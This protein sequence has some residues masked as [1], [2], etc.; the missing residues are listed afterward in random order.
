MNAIDRRSF[1]A[2]TGSL[3]VAFALPPAASLAD[4]LAPP[5][6]TVAPDQVDGFIAID[7]KGLVTLYSGK[8]DLGTG[9]RT[10]MTQIV[11]EELD[12]PMDRVTVI[13]GDTALT[14]DQGTSSGS[15]SIQKGGVQIRQAAA[16]ARASLLQMAATT[17]GAAPADLTIA[18]GIITAKTG[19]SVTY[20]ALIGGKT[21]AL[22]LDPKAPLKN[23]DTYTIVGQSKARLDIPPKVFATF[24][25]MHDFKL[26]GMLHGRVVRP[27]GIGAD[28]R[29][30][31][32][33]SV[34]SIPGVVKIVREGNFLGVVA[35]TEW[36][37]IKASRQLKT[38]WSSWDGLPEDGKLWDHVRTTKV[39]K[40]EV[41]SSV[42]DV[43]SALG[44]GAKRIKATYDFA[45]HT[46]GS[47]GPSCAV[48]SFD[49]DGHLTCWS[50][51]QATHNLVKQ[52]SVMLGMPADKIRCIYIDGSGCYGRNGHEDAAADAVLMAKAVGQPV[53][54]QWMREDEHGWD[55]KG[56]PT[57]IDL[58]AALDDKGDI[59]AWSSAFFIPQ[60]AAGTVPLVAAN[61]TDKPHETIL[62]PGG[63]TGNSALPY[64]LP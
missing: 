33:A 55:P 34:G 19:A 40:D 4:P 12:V 1:L 57:L 3:V 62:A 58:E 64:T 32:E 52:L 31:D 22:K 49:A 21:F 51:S 45:I 5:S 35:K 17:L 39:A 26:P 6:K 29:G 23:P 2:S 20:A 38:S 63:I 54:V 18:D 46:H 15:L 50:A 44:K 27:P 43:T 53:R 59:L 48:A 8:V 61:L 11:A 60:G 42:G 28:L 10:A 7:A 13:Q 36:A 30:F 41:T 47:I 56:P 24:T 16:T 14:P 37:A 25:Y 9:V